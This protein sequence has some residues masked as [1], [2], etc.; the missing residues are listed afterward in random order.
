MIKVIPN[1]TLKDLS[2][3]DE[4]VTNFSFD[5]TSKQILFDIRGGILDLN[6]NEH[7]YLEDV[8]LSISSWDDFDI[9]MFVT[10][11]DKIKKKLDNLDYLDDIIFFEISENKLVLRGFGKETSGWYEWVFINPT[12]NVTYKNSFL[13][14]KY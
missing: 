14:K 9:F 3:A 10:N 11:T 12:I 1:S 5:A 2:F 13:E 8:A 7:E 6:D 4:G